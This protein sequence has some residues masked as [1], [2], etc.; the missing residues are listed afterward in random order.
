MRDPPLHGWMSVSSRSVCCWYALHGRPTRSTTGVRRVK[1]WLTVRR[2][3]AVSDAP[4][5]DEVRGALGVGLDLRSKP[6]DVDVDCPRAT[7][8]ARSPHADEELVAGVGAPGMC[9]KQRKQAE[10]LGSQ[11]DRPSRPPEL[12]GREVE[13]QAIGDRQHPHAR[14]FARSAGLE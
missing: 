6:A 11:V 2:V 12:V 14:G 4:D 3:Q 8:V 13:L 1:T 5:R 10:L 9:R 7:A